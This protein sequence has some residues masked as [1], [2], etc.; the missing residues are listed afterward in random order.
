MATETRLLTADEFFR[1]PGSYKWTEL[2]RGE[3]RRLTPPGG[4][5]GIVQ[6]RVFRPVDDYAEEHGGEALVETGSC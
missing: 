6:G 2:V 5:H 1:I 3:V 4:T